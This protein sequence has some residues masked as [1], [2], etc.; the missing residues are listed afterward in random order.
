MIK[1]SIFLNLFIYLFIREKGREGEREAEKHNV[2]LPLMCPLLETWP[3]TQACALTGNRT[4]HPLI[5]R[6]A[7]NQHQP[8][9]FSWNYF[10]MTKYSLVNFLLYHE[11]ASYFYKIVLGPWLLSSE[12]VWMEKLCKAKNIGCEW[13]EPCEPKVHTSWLCGLQEVISS[14]LALV[15]LY[16]K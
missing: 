4:A 14:L 13:S 11:Q 10:W 12:F 5:H 8:G 9:W 2:W 7:L 6:P 16:I 3:A 15:S 1:K